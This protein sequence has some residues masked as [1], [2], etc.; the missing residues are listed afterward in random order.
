MYN[1]YRH[2]QGKAKQII[3]FLYSSRFRLYVCTNWQNYIAL[4]LNAAKYPIG[5]DFFFLVVRACA[6]VRY[7]GFYIFILWFCRSRR[8]RHIENGQR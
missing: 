6:D 4:L 2:N 7:C 5:I 8:R 3:S 1:I